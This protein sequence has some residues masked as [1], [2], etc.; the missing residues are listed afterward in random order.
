MPPCSSRRN[1][2]C[3]SDRSCPVGSGETDI[4]GEEWD[5]EGPDLDSTR[6]R[7]DHRCPPLEMGLAH[8][9]VVIVARIEDGRE[10]GHI[11]GKDGEFLTRDADKHDDLVRLD[12][13]RTI[14]R[15]DEPGHFGYGKVVDDYHRMGMTISTCS[16]SLDCGSITKTSYSSRFN[17]RPITLLDQRQLLGRDAD[18]L[19]AVIEYPQA[20][21]GFVLQQF[22][23]IA[24]ERVLRAEDALRDVVPGSPRPIR[25][26]RATCAASS[27]RR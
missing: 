26:R 11:V 27:T 15:G 5:G 8:G 9:E 12:L 21:K 1:G 24:E 2:G 17:P 13:L 25:G 6:L 18:P 19:I 4:R 23:E 16:G 22:G 7:Q 14:R 20:A 3:H 10:S